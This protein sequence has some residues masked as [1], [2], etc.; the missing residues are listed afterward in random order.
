MGLLWV[1]LHCMAMAWH[2]GLGN[3][4]LGAFYHYGNVVRPFG[5]VEPGTINRNNQKVQETT[6]HVET[7]LAE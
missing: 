6:R 1:C 7:I 2:D 3:T 4:E 5:E